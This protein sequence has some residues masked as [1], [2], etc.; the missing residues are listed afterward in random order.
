MRVFLTGGTGY[1]G[2]RLIP[3][4][5]GRG[6]WVR[7]LVRPGSESR[8]PAGC[9]PAIGNA[10]ESASLA[11][12]VRAGD[13]VVQLVGVAHPGPS[14]AALFRSVDLASAKASVDAA[15]TAAAAHFVYVSVAQPAPVMKE[16]VAARA[17]AEAY[18]RE[19]ALPATV[20]RPWYV[21]GPGHR[22]PYAILPLTALLKRL[23]KTRETALRLDFVTLRQMLD[24]LARAVE[25]PHDGHRVVTA[26]EIRAGI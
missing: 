22:W 18:L 26:Q 2:S 11:R 1:I 16:Y 4:L 6:H 12:H 9:E 8:L 25:T 24:A 20:L 5:L 21:L 19:S 3:I 10:L 7:A 17:E 23:P 15:R 14:K 13:T